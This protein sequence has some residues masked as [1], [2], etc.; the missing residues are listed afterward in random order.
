MQSVDVWM[1]GLN[2]K[3]GCV[4]AWIEC[5]VWVLERWSHTTTGGVNVITAHLYQDAIM[6]FPHV[7][8]D[9]LV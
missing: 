1:H 4:D 8:L 3:C 6:P 5:K 2:A 9:K 7:H